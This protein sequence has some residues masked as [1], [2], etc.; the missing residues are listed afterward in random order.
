M[1]EELDKTRTFLFR[2]KDFTEKIKAL[3]M[4]DAI[5]EFEAYFPELEWIT[6]EEIVD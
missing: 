1:K 3:E 5:A 2:G 6:V 4:E